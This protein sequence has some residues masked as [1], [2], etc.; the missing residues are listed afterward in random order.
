MKSDGGGGGVLAGH[1]S[2]RQR[3]KALARGWETPGPGPPG[4]EAAASEQP[5]GVL[6]GEAVTQPEE[7]GRTAAPQ[8]LCSPAAASAF[9][10]GLRRWLRPRPGPFLRSLGLRSRPQG[11]RS[12]GQPPQPEAAPGYPAGRFL[13]GGSPCIHREEVAPDSPV[14][15]R[16]FLCA[17]AFTTGLP[18]AGCGLP[19]ADPGGHTCSQCLPNAGML[20]SVY[21]VPG[22]RAW[23]FPSSPAPQQCWLGLR[24]SGCS[25]VREE[26]GESL[27]QRQGTFPK[28][29]CKKRA[30]GSTV[31]RL[32]SQAG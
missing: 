26:E 23:F 27:V 7:S 3:H 12:Y 16:S 11:L 25:R 22:R 15:L 5:G 1:L 28:L 13:R 21:S 18:T 30:A 20:A 31:S 2:L 14:V 4:R 19:E 10:V 32:I 24:L 9:R 17:P 6:A 29:G 8:T